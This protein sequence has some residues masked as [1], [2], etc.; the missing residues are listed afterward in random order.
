MQQ[1]AGYEVA[2]KRFEDSAGDSGALTEKFFED[3]IAGLS[4][5]QKSIHPKYFYDARGSEYFDRIC[6]LEEYYPFRTE[7]ELL[8]RVANELSGVLKQDYDMIEFGAGSL[9]KVK[10]LLNQ[11]GGIRS[12]TPIDISGQHLHK[13]C[14]QLQEEYPELKVRPVVADFSR[15]VQ[16]EA[17]SHKR[18]GFFP[19]STIGNFSP[20]EARSFLVSAGTTLGRGSHMLIGV[21][22][23]KPPHL[24]HSAY[25]DRQGVTAGFNRNLL[26]R[27][28]REL[29]ANFG[30]QDF[31]HYAF[32]NTAKGRVEMH[33][34]SRIAQTVSV[35]G[36][37]I[38]FRE[39]ESIHTENSYKYT[40]MEFKQLGASAGWSIERQWVAK[41]GL[42][43]MYL[44]R[45][46]PT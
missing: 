45:F 20:E 28:N 30:A 5:P 18:L 42:F 15:P 22:T 23:K 25:N 26:E 41:E 43:A 17:S 35:G 16:L 3:V 10:P 1:V 6:A 34:V 19:G 12:F 8:P 11:I 32:Y 29:D 27:I 4:Q 2:A 39:G 31:D 9:Q 40:P 44:L 37:D 46:A 7:L 14:D 21:D 36:V 38:D 33:L 13:A 24:L